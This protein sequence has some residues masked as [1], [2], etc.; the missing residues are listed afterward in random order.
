ML[1]TPVIAWRKERFYV[2]IRLTV[3]QQDIPTTLPR[4]HPGIY[5]WLKARNVAPNGPPFFHY[6]L[7]GADRRML[8]EVGVPVAYAVMGDERVFGGMFPAGEYASLLH[9]GDYRHLMEAH[10][11]LDAWV[12]KSGRCDKEAIPGKGIAFAGRTEFYLTD[13]QATPDPAGWETEIAFFLP[14]KDSRA[15]RLLP[16]AL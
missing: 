1:T 10:M 8:V 12:E 5:A 3:A 6:L 4:L 11:E 14:A 13:G 9:T 15:A 2:A 16:I 7:M